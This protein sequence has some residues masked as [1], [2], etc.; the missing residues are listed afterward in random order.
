MFRELAGAAALLMAALLTGCPAPRPVAP[1][2]EVPPGAEAPAPLELS[3]RVRL[4]FSTAKRRLAAEVYFDHH[5]DLYC[6]CEY[7]DDDRVDASSCGFEA[8]SNEERGARIEWEHMVPAARFGQHRACWRGET[9]DGH[10]GRECCSRSPASGG[11]EEFRAMEG[12][13]HNLAPAVGELNGDRSNR[14]YGIVD[15]EP[16]EY[17]A[18]DFEID[19]DAG[20]DG[21]TEPAESIRGDVARAWLYMSAEWGMQLTAEELTLFE[22]WH[23]SDPPDEWE[24][25]RNQRIA[26][27]Q[28]N[29]NLFVP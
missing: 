4:S 25:A 6:G 28:G 26:R 19:R 24:I 5:V 29:A 17:G 15:E 21:V 18:C 12:D 23:E 9:C 13:M 1:A 16:R 3:R 22:A 7:D 27:V 20:R 8:R 11:D 14:P 2:A 10:R